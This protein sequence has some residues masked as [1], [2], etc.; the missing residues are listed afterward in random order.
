MHLDRT[1]KGGEYDLNGERLHKAA[2]Q[3]DLGVLMHKSQK[4]S[5]Q[6]QQVIGKANRMLA[7]ISKGIKYINREVLRKLYKALVRPHLKYCEQFWSPKERCTGI[8]ISPGLYS[9]EF[10][11]MNGNLIEIEHR[12]VQHSTGP[13]A[14]DVAPNPI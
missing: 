11:R 7:F 10:R 14:H 12:T 13:S 8:G 1:N 4:T 9:L 3:R 6:V 2:A 5:M